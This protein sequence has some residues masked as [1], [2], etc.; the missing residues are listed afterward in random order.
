MKSTETPLR[1]Q[2]TAFLHGYARAVEAGDNGAVAASY[3]RDVHRG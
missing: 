2:I 1:D 3:S